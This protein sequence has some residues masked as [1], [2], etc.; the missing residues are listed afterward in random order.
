M[1]S[2]A[3]ERYLDEHGYESFDLKT[4]MFDMDGVLFDSMK[5]HAT[6][7]HKT[8][9]HFGFTFPMEEAYM[10]EGRTGGGT[11]NIVS[12]RE[13]GRLAT[14]EEIQEIYRYKSGIF[15]KCPEPLSMPGAYDL[16]LKVKN[17]GL[18][19]MVVT[20]SGQKLMLERIHNFFPDIFEESLMVTGFDVK[21]GKPDPEPYLMGLTKGKRYMQAHG[22]TDDKAMMLKPNES[23]VVENAP[24]GI[25]SSV[26]AGLFTIAVNTGPL[27]DSVL[28]DAGANLLYPSMEALCEDWEEV[29]EKLKIK[30]EKFLEDKKTRIQEDKTI[31]SLREN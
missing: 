24:L 27:A 30:N 7:W 8:M 21:K 25:Q 2:E 26:A 11:I 22:L 1:L 16:L 18:L 10:H 28:Y 12:M 4:V 23:L 14:E 13:R 17:S 5:N 6:S 3:I 20:G 29:N 19:P 15:D 31:V 9:T